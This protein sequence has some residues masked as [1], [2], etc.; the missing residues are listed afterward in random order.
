MTLT[1][2]CSFIPSISSHDLGWSADNFAASRHGRESKTL[3]YHTGLVSSH[4]YQAT[5]PFLLH[6]RRLRL[7]L[8]DLFFC[9]HVDLF[10]IFTISGGES[11][12]VC[13]SGLATSAVG[14]FV[15]LS[16]LSSV[17]VGISVSSSQFIFSTVGTS[18][19][20]SMFVFPTT[21]AVAPCRVISSLASP[22]CS[23]SAALSP[24][25]LS[26]RDLSASAT[27]CPAS[28]SACESMTTAGPSTTRIKDVV[29]SE[30]RRV[31]K[32]CRSRWSPYH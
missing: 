21:S 4:P 31:G 23:S 10:L 6:S 11:M 28:A 13:L 25:C 8:G 26:M 2:Q 24:I 17:I 7:D 29:R 18:V 22:D 30:E 5:T 32:E 12:S 16:G 14:M 9:L 1:A 15:S 27:P 20:P 3:E 19:F